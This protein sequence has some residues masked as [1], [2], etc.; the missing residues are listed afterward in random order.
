MKT[1]LWRYLT[2]GAT[3][4]S[5]PNDV[6]LFPQAQHRAIASAKCRL[7]KCDY[8]VYMKETHLSMSFCVLVNWASMGTTP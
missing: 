1:N 5:R 7:V 6:R 2:S 4:P 3:A 8:Q